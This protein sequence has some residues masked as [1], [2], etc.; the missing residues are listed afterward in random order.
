LS[1]GVRRP[2]DFINN[3]LKTF[4]TQYRSRIILQILFR[5]ATLYL[6]YLRQIEK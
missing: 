1:E 5:N 3:R 2:Y 6:H 4:C